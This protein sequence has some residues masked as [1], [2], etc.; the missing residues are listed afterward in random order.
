[1]WTRAKLTPGLVPARR[2]RALASVRDVL[3][4]GKDSG[5]SRLLSAAAGVKGREL[6]GRR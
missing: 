6:R 4:L 1:M 5:E 2:T 3:A